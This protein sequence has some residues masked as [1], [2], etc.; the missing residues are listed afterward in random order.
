MVSK[1]YIHLIKLELKDL[2]DNDNDIWSIS[3]SCHHSTRLKIKRRSL[4]EVDRGSQ[5]ELILVDKKRDKVVTLG[6][7]FKN[8]FSSEIN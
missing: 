2:K 8:I 4:Q 5:V 6:I 7:A 3:F 1:L